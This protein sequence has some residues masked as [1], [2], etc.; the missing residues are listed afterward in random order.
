MVY[1]CPMTVTS[2]RIASSP[3][4]FSAGAQTVGGGHFAA[5]GR[6]SAA[7]TSDMSR[8]KLFGFIIAMMIDTVY[9][10]R[11]LP[12]LNLRHIYLW[13]AVG[14]RPGRGGRADRLRRGRARGRGR[15]GGRSRAVVR[16]C[17]RAGGRACRRACGR[18]G[19]AD[20]RRRL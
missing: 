19:R 18:A 2:A 7:S 5:G 14:D 20:R 6:L 3:F 12:A 9:Q 17:G 8:L 11:K 1:T 15:A 13:R 16:A 4:P 10:N